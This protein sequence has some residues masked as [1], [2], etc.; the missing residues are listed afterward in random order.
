MNFPPNGAL[1]G[2]APERRSIGMRDFH[3]SQIGFN[4]V[5]TGMQLGGAVNRTR[6]EKLR[7][8]QAQETL[9]ITSF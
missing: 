1:F 6:L 4:T 3:Q 5:S 2:L 9:Y 8:M 7:R